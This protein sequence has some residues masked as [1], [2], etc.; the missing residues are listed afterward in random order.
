MAAQSNNVI[1][2]KNVV[3]KFGDFTALNNVSF[4]I[5]EGELFG[6]LGPNGAGKTTMINLILGLLKVTSGTII[7]DREDISRNPERIKKIIGMMTQE[8]VV[9][10]DLTAKQNL[11]LFARLY[12][13]SEAEMSKRVSEA[14]KDANLEDKANVRAGTFSGGMQRRLELVKSMVNVPK[15]LILDE[16]TTGLDVQN[17]VDMWKRIR[18]LSKRG[19]TIIMTTQYLEEADSLCERV[20]VI[21]HGEVKAIGTPLELKKQVA[22]KPIL[23]IFA[24]ADVLDSIA[25]IIRVKYKLK[26][27]ILGEKLL[28][29]ISGDTASVVS[30][31]MKETSKRKIEIYSISSRLPTMDDVFIKLTGSS[32]RD[33]TSGTY[34]ST[35]SKMMTRR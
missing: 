12:G 9:E 15:I 8:T 19:V 23:E 27:E 5:K 3:K 21:D 29:E 24:K 34:E 26:P 25:E 13:L 2:V 35:R 6:L 11:E 4:T 17:R 7:I 32:L 18:E 10:P 28:A 14:L 16:P 31:I 20:A 22:T 1:E 30:G 33:T